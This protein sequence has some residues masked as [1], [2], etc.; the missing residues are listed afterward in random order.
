MTN[1]AGSF[2]APGDAAALESEARRF[3]LTVDDTRELVAIHEAAHAVVAVVQGLKLDTLNLHVRGRAL[4]GFHVTYF[5]RDT[6]AVAVSL[7]AGERASEL[8]LELGGQWT[9][10]RAAICRKNAAADYDQIAEL[11]W[12]PGERLTTET[13][14]ELADELVHRHLHQIVTVAHALI[15]RGSLTGADVEELI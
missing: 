13:I 7:A 14:N 3:G 4:G 6:A 10:R 2:R 15:E 9:E 1:A 5:I 8:W 11:D 12:L